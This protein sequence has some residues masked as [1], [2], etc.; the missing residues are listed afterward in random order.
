[1]VLSS[2]SDH[3]LPIQTPLISIIRSNVPAPQSSPE[4]RI[5]TPTPAVI[6]QRI[7]ANYRTTNSFRLLIPAVHPIAANLSYA[8]RSRTNSNIVNATYICA[9][10]IIAPPLPT[11]HPIAAL[12]P[13]TTTPTVLSVDKVSENS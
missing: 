7:S 5:T 3:L 9:A 8:V 11:P 4:L 6:F 12:L 2:G 1:M 13:A 10:K